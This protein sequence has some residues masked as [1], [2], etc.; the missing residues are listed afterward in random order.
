MTD[1]EFA[2]IIE[3]VQ[4][5]AEAHLDRLQAELWEL[6]VDEDDISEADDWPLQPAGPFCGCTTCVVR[7]VLHAGFHHMKALLED[8]INTQTSQPR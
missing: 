8:E 3:K 4:R 7:E 5:D 2:M 1:A 6:D